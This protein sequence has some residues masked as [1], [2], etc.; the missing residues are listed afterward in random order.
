MFFPY[1]IEI[2]IRG[3][4]LSWSTVTRA[5]LGY[6]EEEMGSLTLFDIL[7]AK[8]LEQIIRA[9]AKWKTMP[10]GTSFNIAIRKRHGL[11]VDVIVAPEAVLDKDFGLM[12]FKCYF[13]EK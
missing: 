5:Y 10:K 9:M 3:K 8:D 11:W 4:F 1:S 2:D 6:T 7:N 12:G 13:K